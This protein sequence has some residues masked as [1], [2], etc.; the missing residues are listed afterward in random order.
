MKWSFLRKPVGVETAWCVGARRNSCRKEARRAETEGAAA[1][2]ML[3][4][5]A[6]R[7]S[8]QSTR[9]RKVSAPGAERTAPIKVYTGKMARTLSWNCRWV[10]LLRTWIRMK[11]G[12]FTGKGKKLRID[13]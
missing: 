10:P 5:C 9:R 3:S 8:F 11:S 1:I 6:M 13:G 4:E 12:G 7:I 2:F